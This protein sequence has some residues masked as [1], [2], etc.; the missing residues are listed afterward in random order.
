[1]NNY[2]FQTPQ[3]VWQFLCQCLCPIQFIACVAVLS[4]I[5]LSSFLNTYTCTCTCWLPVW[6]LT[7]N[8]LEC[9]LLQ[10]LSIHFAKSL[11]ASNGN[12]KK[13][14]GNTLPTLKTHRIMWKL[15]AGPQIGHSNKANSWHKARCF[16][17]SINIYLV[18]KLFSSLIC[19]YD[20]V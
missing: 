16:I 8:C 3:G 17:L 12:T 10:V 14:N 1:M 9:A 4:C 20:Q 5:T 2:T 18:I 19:N 6:M 13:E 11:D 7:R 15:R